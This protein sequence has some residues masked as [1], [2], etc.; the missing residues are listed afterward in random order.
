MDLW[1]K[2]TEDKSS[3]EAKIVPLEDKFKLLGEYSMNL[4]EE[5]N[6]KRMGLVKAWQDFNLMLDRIQIR[7]TKVHND[8]YL[9]T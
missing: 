8:L 3:V 5:D 4:K 7:N 2:L 6:I 1:N 9:E